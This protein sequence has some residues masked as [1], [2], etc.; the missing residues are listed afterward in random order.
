MKTFSVQKYKADTCGNTWSDDPAEFYQADDIKSIIT[1][2]S[3]KYKG[4]ISSYSLNGDDI[5][6][7]IRTPKGKGY[8]IWEKNPNFKPD[9][10][11]CTMVWANITTGLGGYWIKEIKLNIIK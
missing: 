6:S 10:D 9:K 7:S 11:I 8:G 3:K 4:A 1:F 5:I 2:I